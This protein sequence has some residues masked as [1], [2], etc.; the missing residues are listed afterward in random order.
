MT[1][2][3]MEIGKRLNDSGIA[4]RRFRWGDLFAD[5]ARD[6]RYGLRAIGKAPV[7]TLFAV[8]TLALGIGA[9]TT[10]FT[11]VNTILLHPMPAREPSRLVV[12]YDTES[13][14]SSRSG[15]RL[16]LSYANFNDYVAQQ[17]SFTDIA[18]Y[19]LPLMM[20][21]RGNQGPQRMFGQLVTKTYFDTLGLKPALGRFFAP[22]EDA[23]PGSAPV[24][25]L[26]YNAWQARFGGSPDVIGRTLE[27]NEIAFT[28]IG[29]APK[30][31]LGISAI[32]G[33][34]VTLPATMCER[35]FPMQFGGAIADRSKSLFHGI[36]RLRPGVTLVQA[37]ANLDPISLALEREYPNANQGH[38]IAVRPVSDELYSGL[39]DRTSL[40]FGSTV[41]LVIVA[42]VLATACANVA[43]LLLARATARRQETAV[44]LA[45]GA[46]RGRLIRQYLTESL[47]LSLLSFVA[48]LAVGY[49]G[50]RVVWS[51][52]P[53]E[54]MQNLAAPKLDTTVFLLTFLVSVATAFLFGIAPAM[55]ASKTDVVSALKE[56]TRTGE[57]TRRTVTF[58]HVLLVIQ[59]AFS[60]VTLITATL[61]I[62][63]IQRA[64]TIDPG[65]D[66][67]HLAIFMMHPGQA[68]YGPT[69]VKEF[70]RATRDRV[71]ALPGVQSAS[72]SSAMPFWNQ[73]SRAV[74]IQGEQLQEKSQMTTPIAE[75]VDTNYFTTMAIPILEGR[76]FAD[77]D[78]EKSI[79]V[80]IVNEEL[81]QKYW[82]GG[83]ALGHTFRFAGEGTVRQVVGV[84]KTTNYTTLGEKPQ[85]CIYVPLRQN[86]TE[87]M[88]LYVRSKRDP[89]SI[90]TAVTSSIRASD[91]AI[92]VSDVRTGSKLID[93]VLFGP[94]IGV[95]LLGGF[96]SLA[97]ALASIG[98]YGVMAYSINRR[99]K[100]IGIRMALGASRST[101]LAL[102][103]REGMTV[104]AIGVAAGLG[105]SLLISGALSRM[106][107]G[108]SSADPISLTLAS[109]VL[110]VVAL[111]ACY[112]PAQSATRIDTMHAL[113][114]S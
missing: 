77:A 7:F 92:Q 22:P 89:V 25:V 50:C 78:T 11:I 34:D 54:V 114:E 83:D 87:G 24:A 65:F 96:G 75:T 4:G 91:P 79:P 10:V 37:Q 42:L 63:S 69:R 14:Q 67:G 28:I 81:A 111:F 33:P 74:T 112:L 85:P 108:I 16:S 71:S 64:Y 100:E 104:V 8:L 80:A 98:L 53:P 19:T 21:A 93:Q 45:I 86:F 57:R 46:N 32:F 13:K 99:R 26:S 44:R 60:L 72:W 73:P 27:L 9:N 97:L 23:S 84:V 35:A 48:G 110:L 105:V 59:V 30:G 49:A 29:V 17:S 6:L 102:L 52:F 20:T 36:A 51:F 58:A 38:A 113:R 1:D 62:R 12:L 43:N 55:R 56:E 47:L 109:A 40:V 88:T 90:L 106:L 39:G 107:F 94:K 2:W 82:P 68:G 101:V 103:L 18:A 3:K 95:Q 41:L 70:F 61:F 76:D 66:S 5:F 15:N 31:F